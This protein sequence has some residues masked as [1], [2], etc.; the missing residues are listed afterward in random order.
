MKINV[1][2]LESNSQIESKI[3]KALVTDC[4]EYFNEALSII[5]QELPQIIY[6]AITSRPEYVSLVSGKLRLELGIPDA[7]VKVA[8]LINYWISNISYNY[9]K[10]TIE[11]NKIKG[12]INIELIKS[13]FSDILNSN[14]AMVIDSLRAYSLPWLQWLLL[15]GNKVIVPRYNVV[16]SPNPRSRTGGALMR[17]STSSWKVPSEYAG[18]INDNWITRS[19]DNA[20]SAIDGLLER[21][22][23][24]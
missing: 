21:A 16:I 17:I 1:K 5:Q 24:Q 7:S 20:S 10:P 2:I 22:F 13:D 3:L 4:R 6:S 15:D 8:N 12:Y 9:K 11:G 23:K 14:D 18:T 19:I